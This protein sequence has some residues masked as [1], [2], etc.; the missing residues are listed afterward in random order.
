MFDYLYI[1]FILIF[2]SLSLHHELNSK[3]NSSLNNKIHSINNKNNFI[4]DL[5]NESYFIYYIQM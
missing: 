3:Y 4:M 2:T 5:I 1:L